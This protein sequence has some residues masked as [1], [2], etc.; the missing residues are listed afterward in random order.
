MNRGRADLHLVVEDD[1]QQRA[2]TVLRDVAYV[3]EAHF[4][5]TPL[6]GA[7]DNEGKHL[8]CFNRRARKGQCFHRPC[9]GC[10]EFPADFRLLEDGEQPEDALPADQRD[11]DLGWMLHDIDFADGMTPRFFRA[12][13]RD[14]VIEVAARGDPLMSMLAALKGCYDRL[15]EDDAS[16]IA[17]FGYSEEKISF[18]LV[19]SPAGTLGRLTNRPSDSIRQEARTLAEC[20]CRSRSSAPGIRHRA[21]LPLGQGLL[22]PWCRA[23]A[24]GPN[25]GRAPQRLADEHRSFVDAASRGAGRYR[26]RRTARTARVPATLGAGAVRQLSTTGGLAPEPEPG[27]SARRRAALSA[28]AARGARALGDGRSP[29]RPAVRVSVS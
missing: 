8:D 2:A 12:V 4:E 7:D 20:W 1:R 26:R 24:E 14:G 16:G 5:L 6:A 10:R 19:L 17:P 21:D 11:R 9:L 28:P 13:M 22:C 18:A 3:I 27:L 15:A 25:G 23:K 29:A